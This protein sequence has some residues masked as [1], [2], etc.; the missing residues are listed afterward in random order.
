[1]VSRCRR[2]LKIGRKI[3]KDVG[4]RARWTWNAATWS[5]VEVSGMVVYGDGGI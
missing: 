1:M 3:D 5:G 4:N 2:G